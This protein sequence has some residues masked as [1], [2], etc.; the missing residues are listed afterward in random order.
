M[1][2]RKETPES[3]AREIAR[4]N[5]ATGSLSAPTDLARSE[6]IDRVRIRKIARENGDSYQIETM[7]GA[8]AFHENVDSG[9][10]ERA[11][12]SLIGARF[13][14]GEFACESVSLSV[15]TNRRGELGAIRRGTKTVP[16][17]A[18]SE[19]AIAS[20]A[21]LSHNREKRYVIPEGAPLP[22]LVDLGVMTADGTVVKSRYDKFRQ[23]NR[24]LE[25][26]EDVIPDLEKAAGKDE[27]GKPARELT[28]V[29]FGCGK[30]YLTFATY[31][32]LAIKRALPVRIVGLDLK[33]DV[34]ERC[35]SLARSYGYDGLSFAVGDIAGY[36]GLDR[37]DMVVTLHACDTATDLALAR[38]VRWGASVI[39]SVPC[40]Q[41][42]LNGL[43]SSGA[44][45]GPAKDALAGAFRHGIVRDRLAALF[46]DAMRAELL[47]GAGYRVQILEFID[48]SHTPKNLLI[49]AV[50]G[51]ANATAAST[52]AYRAL[53]DF[54]G[55]GIALEEELS[56][57]TARPKDASEE[58]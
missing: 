29:D 35:E 18:T 32:Y 21:T 37:A 24:F 8:K 17:A 1:S 54:L 23:I 6:G 43:L 39:L 26:I 27:T 11:L 10:L 9:G 41:H 7:R 13:A 20:R 33:E 3:L 40:C 30:S 25:F 48:M 56:G 57:K 55:A 52:E 31:W 19:G 46:T 50:R 4:A 12:A 42:E 36:G 28:V 15:L 5:P 44:A 49:R 51:P 53:R 58:R 45:S 14:R 47:S 34:I 22:F 2:K 16:A 38:A